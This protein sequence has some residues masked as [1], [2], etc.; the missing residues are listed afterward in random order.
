MVKFVVWVLELASS[1]VDSSSSP[2]I[3]FICSITTCS[4]SLGILSWVKSTSNF[5]SI[6]TVVGDLEIVHE[7][8]VILLLLL[9]L[10]NPVVLTKHEGRVECL[11]EDNT[12]AQ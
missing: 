3:N 2:L 5:P 6:I 1:R 9:N 4:A 11:S 7:I 8:P 12:C 10:C